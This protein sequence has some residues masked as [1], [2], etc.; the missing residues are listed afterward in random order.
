M[1]INLIGECDKR[2]VLY[3]LMKIC[4][5]LGDVL[6]VTSSS[7]L[8]RLSDTRESGGH[9]QNVMIHFTQDGIDDFFE[10]ISYDS[11]SFECI[12]VDNIITASADLTIYVKSYIPSA[13]EKDM[14]EYLEDYVE[15]DLYRGNY[16]S[17][18]VYLNL[19]KFES[20]SNMEPISGPI[21][22][23]LATTLAPM[24]K[25]SPKNIKNIALR[26]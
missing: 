14:I 18:K 23:K 9:Y 1:I 4:Q 11:S 24:L 2:P 5:D 10:S 6:L 25:V 17:N 13:R 7:R 15:I 20:L 19:E 16:I 21:A 3:T 22:E 12:I 26:A 8:L